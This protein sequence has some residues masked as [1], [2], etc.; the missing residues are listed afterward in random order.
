MAN[1]ALR[2]AWIRRKGFIL[3]CFLPGLT[4][5]EGLALEVAKYNWNQLGKVGETFLS[6]KQFVLKAVELD[7]RNIRHIRGTRLRTDFEVLTVAVANYYNRYDIDKAAELL[8]H[9]YPSS[10]EV[11]DTM[12]PRNRLSIPAMKVGFR[13]FCDIDQLKEIFI[14]KLKLHKF[15]LLDF[16]RGIAIPSSQL[17]TTGSGRNQPVSRSNLTMLDRGEETSEAFKRLIGEYL[18]VPIGK[19]VTFIRKA[20]DNINRPN[21]YYPIGSPTLSSEDLRTEREREV[22]GVELPLFPRGRRQH[23]RLFNNNNDINN[24]AVVSERAV[25]PRQNVA[26]GRLR[27]ERHINPLRQDDGHQIPNPNLRRNVAAPP[28]RDQA[29]AQGQRWPRRALNILFG[30]NPNP[31]VAI[32]P[33]PVQIVDQPL[34]ENARL[35]MDDIDIDA[36]DDGEDMAL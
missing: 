13:D 10:S 29:P 8:K 2:L 34:L 19:E 7:G 20:L 6:D 27:L 25:V 24:F 30:G 23:L 5:D 1:R 11:K 36:H 32:P 14:R 18:A 9:P 28:R 21:N 26:R 17:T 12:H 31:P 33:P 22:L 35:R 4:T 16:L 15:Y 3:N